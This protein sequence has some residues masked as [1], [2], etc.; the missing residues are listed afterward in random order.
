[1]TWI[2][3][4][5]NEPLMTCPT[6][7]LVV[8]SPRPTELSNL[9]EETLACEATLD[10]VESGYGGTACLLFALVVRLARVL[11]VTSIFDDDGI[12]DFGNGSIALL[13]NSLGNAHDCCCSCEVACRKFVELR[14]SCGGSTEMIEKHL[15][16]LMWGIV[17]DF[18]RACLWGG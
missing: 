2:Y 15:E 1:M 11:E 8:K 18:M 10:C 17:A 7:I 12:A 9:R 14:K 4:V 13:E 6:P 3:L 16:V 5:N